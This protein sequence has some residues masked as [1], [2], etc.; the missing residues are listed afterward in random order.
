MVQEYKNSDLDLFKKINLSNPKDVFLKKKLK[1]KLKPDDYEN[2]NYSK[3]EILKFK[4]LEEGLTQI[5]SK[6]TLKIF[7]IK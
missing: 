6:K 4:N 2:F 7:L 1:N 3:K 5:K